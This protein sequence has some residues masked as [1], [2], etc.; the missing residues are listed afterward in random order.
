MTTV[1]VPSKAAIAGH[2]IHA[3]LVPF[4]IGCFTLALSTDLLYWRTGLMMWQNF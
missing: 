2:P 3:A 4:P 1:P